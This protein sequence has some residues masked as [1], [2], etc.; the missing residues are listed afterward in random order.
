M[1]RA[2][3]AA[4]LFLCFSS[5]AA[6]P[7]AASAA[8]PPAGYTSA[9]LAELKTNKWQIAD[10]ARQMLAVALVDC[11]ANPDPQ[12]RD[13]LAF[14]GLQALMRSGA[15]DRDTMDRLYVRLLAD[16]GDRDDTAGLRRPFDALALA[17]VARVDRLAPFLTAEDRHALVFRAFTYLSTLR[18][19]RGF[20]E[21]EGWRHGI[22][23]AADLVLQL[24]LNPQIDAVE[25]EMLRDAVGSQVLASGGHW[26]LYGEPERLM[27]PVFYLAR[28]GWWTTAQWDAWFGELLA[29]LPAQAF[30]SN[31]GLAAH[32]NATAFLTALYVAVRESG[33]ADV[34]AALLQP[35]RKAL[36]R[37]D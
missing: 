19:Y 9:S 27:S 2:R 29:K 18:D 36:K 35:L 26:Y 12:L 3:I 5:L 25:G 17:E 7:T 15:L 13:D 23:H 33:N 16:L 8:C 28:R 14:D 37:L 21:K 34:E 31:A 30:K 6:G 11:L 22:A 10:P 4:T 1:E 20:D 32:H 24:A